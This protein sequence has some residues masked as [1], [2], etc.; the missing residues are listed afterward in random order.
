MLDEKINRSA[1][2]SWAKKQN[3]AIETSPYYS[4][5]KQQGARAIMLYL[6]FANGDM[7]ALPYTSL[8]KLEY[9]LSSGIQ[10]E[11][12]NELLEIKGHHLKPLFMA[13]VEHRV[14]TITENPDMESN[15]PEALTISSIER[16]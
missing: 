11:W 5:E 6:E 7:L 14:K 9:R 12:G 4:Q 2:S 10:M 15:A 8:M 3:L 1:E 13:L 16:E